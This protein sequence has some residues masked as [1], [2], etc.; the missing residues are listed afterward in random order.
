MSRI[1]PKKLAPSSSAI[2]R[3]AQPTHRATQLKQTG[4]RGKGHED[5][6][7]YVAGVKDPSKRVTEY[8]TE[9]DVCPICHTD[10]QFNKNLRLLVSPCYHKMCESCIDRLFTLGPEPCPQCGRILRKVNFAHQT[11]ED[12]KVE[13]EVSVRRRMADIFNKRRDDFESDRQYDDYLELVEDLTFNLLNDISIPETEAR[14]TEWQRQNESVIQTN[15]HK[16]EEESMSQSKREE[17]E[18]RAREERMRMIEEAERVERMEDERIKGEVT[19]ALAKGETKRAR[20]IEIEAREAKRLRAEALFKFVP[21]S[22]LPAQPQED[23]SHSPLSPSYNGPFIPIPYSDPDTAPWAGWYEAKGE[24]VDRR[25]G[26]MFIREDRE[27]RVRGGGYDLQL[28]WEMEVR[29]AV[30]ALG[31]EPLV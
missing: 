4:P 15:K 31:V 7:L 16:A 6:Y 5:G 29:S 14:I 21:P 30:E 27:E 22:L 10:R 9:Q 18:R 2:R 8:R 28:F 17:I 19:Q 26:V 3:P 20:E 25:S 13:K 24:Y 1:P 11:F 12:L 23:V